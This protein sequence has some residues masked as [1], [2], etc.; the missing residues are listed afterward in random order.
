MVYKIFDAVTVL[1]MPLTAK[2]LQK[3]NHYILSSEEFEPITEDLKKVSNF[4]AEVLTL[5]REL[6][7][8]KDEVSEQSQEK[9][10]VF[11]DLDGYPSVGQVDNSQ[12]ENA[13]K[14]RIKGATVVVT[15]FDGQQAT[16]DIDIVEEI[17]NPVL[18]E[19]WLFLGQACLGDK[20]I[21][22]ELL[23]LLFITKSKF[24]DH[25]FAHL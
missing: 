6:K 22:V 8:Y 15:K 25:K 23:L 20:G 1:E 17:V 13:R 3:T 10:I 5:R 14:S 7:R 9:P 12:Y 16:I 11:T 19:C 18:Y 24:L 21:I 2:N 4:W